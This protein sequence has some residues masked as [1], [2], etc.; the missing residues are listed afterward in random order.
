M[1]IFLSLDDMIGG[2]VLN[3]SQTYFASVLD[4]LAQQGIDSTQ[5]LDAIGFE[6]FPQYKKQ[7]RVPLNYYSALLDYGKRILNDPLFGFHVGCDVHSA[8][9]GV[10]GYLIESSENLAMAIKHL[11]AFD[12]LVA[13]IGRT[14][15]SVNHQQA[16]IRWTPHAQGSEQI[17]LRNMAAWLTT[18]R[19]LLGDNLAPSRISLSHPFT[20]S[21]LRQLNQ[22]LNCEVVANQPFNEISFPSQL[23]QHTFRSENPQLHQTMAAISQQELASINANQCAKS[24]IIDLLRLKPDLQDCTL[25]QFASVFNMSSR[26]LQRQLKRAGCRFAQLLDDERKQRTIKQL[27]SVSLGELSLQLGFNEQS[28]FNRAFRRWFNCS[29]R[30]YL[31]RSSRV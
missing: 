14:D 30:V 17:V 24:E 27:G 13:N 19:Q 29:P 15:F 28:S 25:L 8:D 3:T 18:A 31:S 23:L 6:D 22:H 12:Q 7:Q 16:S 5:A 2:A 9:Y 11:L 21:Q 4:F 20:V 10:L 1:T 26:T